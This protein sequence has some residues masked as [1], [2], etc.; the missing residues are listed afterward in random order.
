[1]MLKYEVQLGWAIIG[2]GL[3]GSAE[4]LMAYSQP[5]W[6]LQLHNR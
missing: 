3:V 4:N 2:Y 6:S 5:T 1:M